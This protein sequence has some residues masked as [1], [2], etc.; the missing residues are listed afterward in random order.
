M[1]Q[2]LHHCLRPVRWGISAAVV[3][4]F[5]TNCS[6][7]KISTVGNGGAKEQTTTS[8]KKR[9]PGQKTENG[10]TTGGSGFNKGSGAIPDAL[11]G[12]LK[13]CGV[14]PEKIS[15]PAAQ[16]SLMNLTSLTKVITGSENATKQIA[17][18][19]PPVTINVQY[20]IKV[21][22]ELGIDAKSTQT[23]QSTSPSLLSA[24]VTN[25]S[26]PMLSMATPEV[27]AKAKA[28][29]EAQR[30][31]ST[32]KNLTME[33]RFELMGTN[34]QWDGIVC[35]IQPVQEVVVK[36]GS[37]TKTIRFTP[38]LPST[39]SPIAIP[40]VYDSEI[41]GG[42]NFTDIK[43]EVIS[44]DDPSMP[45]GKVIM[46]SVTVSKVGNSYNVPADANDGTPRTI[47]AEAGYNMSFNFGNGA[48][49]TQ[50]LGLMPSQTFLINHSAKK[51][52]WVAA[53][54]GDAKLKTVIMVNP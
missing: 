6:T 35:T 42:R 12:V 19:L 34:P 20:E 53:D 44:S 15:D 21:K 43:A 30:G 45:A 39:I 23:L 46:G 31:G 36:K 8:L 26:E 33:E 49:D 54:T 28:E 27:Q 5:M 40:E 48:A 37:F 41:G 24:R 47:S 51:L 2:S 32:S 22:L 1:S 29:I 13:D 3:V 4:F 18:F 52:A 38:A 7:D 17:P 9:V 10:Q 14:D 50:G 11:L 16:L 25:L